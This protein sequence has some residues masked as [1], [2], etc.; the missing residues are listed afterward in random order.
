MR[1]N[2]RVL[3]IFIKELFTEDTLI[4][5]EFFAM[6]LWTEVLSPVIVVVTRTDTEGTPNIFKIIDRVRRVGPMPI[7]AF[8]FMQILC[9]EWAGRASITSYSSRFSKCD[10]STI[11]ITLAGA[12]SYKIIRFGYSF[13]FRRWCCTVRRIRAVRCRGWCTFRR[14]WNLEWDVRGFYFGKRFCFG[15]RVKINFQCNNNTEEKKLN[16]QKSLG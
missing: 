12:A 4:L 16:T 7:I 10:T 15:Q 9:H 13:C 1:R 8:E 14:K 6:A 11:F 3:I 5:E 2:F